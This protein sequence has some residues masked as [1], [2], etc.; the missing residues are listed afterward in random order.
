VGVSFSE[1]VEVAAA[2]V[3]FVGGGAICHLGEVCRVVCRYEV[4]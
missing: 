1:G 3:G 2:A 4:G